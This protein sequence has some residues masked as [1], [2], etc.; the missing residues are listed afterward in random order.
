MSKEIKLAGE[1]HNRIGRDEC[2]ARFYESI[3]NASLVSEVIFHIVQYLDLHT[4]LRRQLSYDN[5]FPVF[6]HFF[7]LTR[8]DLYDQEQVYYGTYFLKQDFLLHNL[9]AKKH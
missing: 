5:V 9:R 4:S 6:C 8:P 7:E 2:H 3:K 1:I